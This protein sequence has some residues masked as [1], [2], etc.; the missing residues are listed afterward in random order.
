MANNIVEIKYRDGGNWLSVKG[1]ATSWANYSKKLKEGR[2]Q[3][4]FL[5]PVTVADAWNGKESDTQHLKW[6]VWYFQAF[7]K[8]SETFDIA[9]LKSCSDIEIIQYSYNDG[10]VINTTYVPDTSKNEYFNISE[11]ERAADTSGQKFDIIFRT[12]RTIINKTLPLDFT[13]NITFDKGT[14]AWEFASSGTIPGKLS[15]FNSHEIVSLNN[16]VLQKYKRVNNEWQKTG[17][18][19]LISGLGSN[20]DVAVLD[21]DNVAVMGDGQGFLSKYNFDGEQW[22]IVGNAL[23]VAGTFDNPS[24]TGLSANRIALYDM[25]V[26]DLVTL[27][28]DGTDW[29]PEGNALPF[30]T[31]G[32][33]YL[34]KLTSGKIAMF[35]MKAAI[36][37]FDFDGTDWTQNE[38]VF[39]SS[40][41]NGAVCRLSDTRIATYTENSSKLR[42]YTLT[43]DWA[44][45]AGD[46]TIA[47]SGSAL[48]GLED[49]EVF[50]RCD[51]P[52]IYNYGVITYYSDFEVLDWNKPTEDVEV[53]WFD[54]TIKKAQRTNK[55]GF[56]FVQYILT[57]DH[58]GFIEDL[59]AS[60]LTK[61]NGTEIKEVDFDQPAIVGEGLIKIVV[62]GVSVTTLTTDYLNTNQDFSLS[63]N[64]GGGAE[65]F[66][67]DYRIEF[68]S[69]TPDINQ[70]ENQTGINET[71]KA[72]SK[73][74]RTF[75]FY[76][77]EAAA[78]N[79][80]TKFEV[81]A[82][83]GIIEPGTI[84]VLEN[85][86][87]T[88]T[89]LG[90]DLWE[91]IVNCLTGVTP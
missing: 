56:E 64:D 38:N 9:K 44:V 33:V 78:F 32:S 73:T 68:T 12:N 39:F 59:K 23:N 41:G 83:T 10:T 48:V 84:S 57:S 18:S 31:T 2:I 13:N 50:L 16:S 87:V 55:D 8:E 36:R 51:T 65:L 71:S 80:K 85:R 49:N 29:A 19:I 81:Y 3:S 54:N 28:F 43:S 4:S 35:D 22:A 30:A 45:D 27:D 61:I 77:T 53:Q 6:D 89:R 40:V 20:Q 60:T 52:G 21:N 14:N 47:G 46:L 63:L 1:L 90:D 79:L 26:Q 74:I 67:T 75:K 76:M 24:I 17:N 70:T 5:L 86:E 15:S 11:P 58:D 66:Y 42:S 62:R 91:V 37:D 72:I 25:L 34:E 88:P 82:E 7:T 69:E